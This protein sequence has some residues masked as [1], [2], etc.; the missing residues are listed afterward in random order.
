MLSGRV[1]KNHPQV[2]S[3]LK[4]VKKT[5]SLA[6]SFHQGDVKASQAQVM[7]QGAAG[8]AAPDDQDALQVNDPLPGP[9]R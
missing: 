5:H 1:K 9:A 4:R 6:A 8:A 2:S 3:N 7:G